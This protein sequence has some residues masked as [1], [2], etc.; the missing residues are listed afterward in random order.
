[1]LYTLAV[2]LLIAWLLGVVGTYTIGAFVHVL[3]VIALVLFLVG[4]I[5]AGDQHSRSH[6]HCLVTAVNHVGVHGSHGG[7]YDWDQIEKKKWKQLA[8]SAR[9]RWGKLTDSD[10][11]VVAG[12]KDQLVGRLRRYGTA[13]DDAERQA[14]EWA[15]TVSE[16]PAIRR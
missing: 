13:K 16:E 5:S 2:I 8:G 9:E 6:F 10:W 4:L 15:R 1:M 12:K 7:A 14:D 3:L 11:Q